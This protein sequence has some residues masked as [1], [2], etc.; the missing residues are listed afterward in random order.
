MLED[1]KKERTREARTVTFDP[2]SICKD[3]TDEGSQGVEYKIFF[4][5]NAALVVTTVAVMEIC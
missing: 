5:D 3:G 2:S 1:R 4:L